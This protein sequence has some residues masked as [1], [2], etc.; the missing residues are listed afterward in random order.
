MLFSSLTVENYNFLVLFMII[1]S[2][3][4][5]LLFSNLKLGRKATTVEWGEVDNTVGVDNQWGGEDNV[6]AHYI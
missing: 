5:N 4:V 3:V 1:E 6:L 2:F